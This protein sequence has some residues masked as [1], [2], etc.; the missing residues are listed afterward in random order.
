MADK[1]IMATGRRKT[2]IAVVK[3]VKVKAEFL[4]T[5]KLLLL[6]LVTE[7]L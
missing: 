3:L 2:A 7:L 4:L 5:V 1:E 6:T